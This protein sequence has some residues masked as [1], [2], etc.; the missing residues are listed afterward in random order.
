MANKN[1]PLCDGPKSTFCHPLNPD[2][3]RADKQQ[4]C[5]TCGLLVE[6][7]PKGER[8]Q[9]ELERWREMHGADDPTDALRIDSVRG[10]WVR[11]AERLQAVVDKLPKWGNRLESANDVLGCS[12]TYTGPAR[13]EISGVTREMCE[14]AQAKE[15]D[16]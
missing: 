10:K 16:R 6:Y 9:A 2:I 12:S 1:C 11:K 4:E 13:T 5:L 14:A 15:T 3:P 8:L 7:W